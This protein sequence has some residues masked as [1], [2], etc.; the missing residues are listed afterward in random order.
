MS[1]VPEAGE[2]ASLDPMHQRMLFRPSDMD[3]VS[4]QQPLSS[5]VLVHVCFPFWFP[6]FSV[7]SSVMQA[8]W[9]ILDSCPRWV[10][11]MAAQGGWLAWLPR[12]AAQH[13]CPI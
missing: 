6:G 1:D 13:S 10:P 4:G 11:E 9:G 2:M 3:M 12:M 8:G 7:A 5:I